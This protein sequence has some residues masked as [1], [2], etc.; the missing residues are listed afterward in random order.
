MSLSLSASENLPCGGSDRVR[1]VMGRPHWHDV[2]VRRGSTISVINGGHGRELVANV[3]LSN[4]VLES[5][6]H[7]RPSV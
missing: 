1:S 7:S 3:V 5:W 6:F 4:C 2:E